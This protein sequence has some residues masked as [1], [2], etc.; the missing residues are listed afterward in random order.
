MIQYKVRK[1]LGGSKQTTLLLFGKTFWVC[2]R[3]KNSGWFRICGVGITWVDK[4]I[5]PTFSERIGKRKKITIGN[6][7]FGYLKPY[8]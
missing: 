6:Y 4:N 3:A 7:R 1:L 2:L 5:A 8:I